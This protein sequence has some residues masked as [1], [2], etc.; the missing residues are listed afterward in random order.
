MELEKEIAEYTGR[1]RL[2]HERI[3]PEG[4]EIV[5]SVPVAPPIGY[6]KTPSLAEQIRLMVRSERMRQA[7]LEAGAETF[8]EADDFDVGDDFDPSSPYEETFDPIPQPAPAPAPEPPPAAT[9]A[10]PAASS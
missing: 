7:A 4:R 8:E 1:Y 6:K 9:P 3:N 5:S 2:R 10:S